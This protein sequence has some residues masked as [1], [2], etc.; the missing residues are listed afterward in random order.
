MPQADE[1][2]EA[3]YDESDQTNLNV[4]FHLHQRPDNEQN[5]E[6]DDEDI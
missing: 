3:H 1:R 4:C 5:N 6:D 2:Q